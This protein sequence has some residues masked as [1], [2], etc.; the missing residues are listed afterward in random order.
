MRELKSISYP[1][2]SGIGGLLEI[3]IFKD[4]ELSAIIGPVF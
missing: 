1:L 3:P 4:H 2:S